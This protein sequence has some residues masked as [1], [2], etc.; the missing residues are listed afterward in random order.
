MVFPAFRAAAS[1]FLRVGVTSPCE[2]SSSQARPYLSTPH[3]HANL[4]GFLGPKAHSEFLGTQR[5]RVGPCYVD[6]ER[7]SPPGPSPPC[8]L[9]VLTGRS[10]RAC[11]LHCRPQCKNVPGASLQCPSAPRRAHRARGFPEAQR[12]R[13]KPAVQHL[14]GSL[15][16]PKC[17]L[18]PGC[19]FCSKRAA[20]C[21][22]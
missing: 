4:R 13:T 1:I 10:R 7:R 17:R 9:T 16:L 11:R 6:A 19:R 22:C 12:N 3:L 5:S 20:G 21:S 2:L 15:P 14:Q 8:D 18:Y